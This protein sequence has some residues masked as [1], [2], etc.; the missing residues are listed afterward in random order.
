ML[1]CLH[2][3]FYTLYVYIFI[4]IYI[5]IYLL[6]VCVCVCGWVCAY[7]YIRSTT[8]YVIPDHHEETHIVLTWYPVIA[9]TLCDEGFSQS[10]IT[11]ETVCLW[12]SNDLWGNDW[13]M[14]RACYFVF[15]FPIIMIFITY[16]ISYKTFCF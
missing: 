6:C 12:I 4:S 14:L 10:T 9:D 1:H 11:R 2:D 16:T 8:Y 7:I 3:Q 15:S 5:Y 13:R